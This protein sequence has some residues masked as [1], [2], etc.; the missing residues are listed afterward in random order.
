VKRPTGRA[1][2]HFRRRVPC[3]RF[4]LS[5]LAVLLLTGLASAAQAAEKVYRVGVLAPEGMHAI[6]S[7]KEGLQQLG[8][9]EGQNIRFDYRTAGGDD[10][11]QPA[12]AAELVALPVDLILTWGT[13]ATL[14]AKQATTTIPIVMGSMGDPVTF[15]VVPNLAHPG[16]NVTGFASQA[17]QIEE[18]RFELLRDLVPGMTRIVMLG[19][20]GNPYADL[21][22]KR[23]ET[24][25]VAAGLKFDGVK[26]DPENGLEGG[27]DMVRRARPDGVLVAAVPVFYSPR[28]YQPIIAF[29]AANRLPA[30]Y[31]AREFVEAG[32][33]ISYSTNYDDLLRQAA[34]YVDKILRGTLPGEL[35]IQQASTFELLVNG[36]TAKALGLAIP[37]LILARANEVIE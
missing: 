4:L 1:R 24:V 5:T 29:M 13:P 10:T 7:F 17:F 6:E 12:L 32:G 35:P 28:I 25:V 27:M 2:D 9:I 34:G 31:S 15:G 16:G 33:L 14:A 8:W 22:M 21:A 19:N 37:P 11:R 26:I 20:I 18:K 3:D 30:I 23:V 36:T